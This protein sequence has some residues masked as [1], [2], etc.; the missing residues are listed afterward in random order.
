MIARLAPWLASLV[1]SKVVWQA[2]ILCNP[3]SGRL[4]ITDDR[5][6]AGAWSLDQPGIGR[7]GRSASFIFRPVPPRERS[8]HS[9]LFYKTPNQSHRE[10]PKPL[11]CSL[12]PL[13][14]PPFGHGL[15]F[16]SQQLRECINFCLICI[17]RLRCGNLWSQL[18][19]TDFC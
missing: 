16:S 2:G 19:G 10:Y 13:S 11:F 18:D 1:G 5:T 6:T 9:I 17:R 7:A 8:R 15:A 4:P 3:I 14:P 12:P